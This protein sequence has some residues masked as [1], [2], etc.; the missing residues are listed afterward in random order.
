MSVFPGEF[1]RIV[2][3]DAFVEI[4]LLFGHVVGHPAER[5]LVFVMEEERILFAVHPVEQARIIL[6][7]VIFCVRAEADHEE[8]VVVDC[9]TRTGLK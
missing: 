1:R 2:C 9:A 4:G 5:I 8:D 3:E 7:V 6:I